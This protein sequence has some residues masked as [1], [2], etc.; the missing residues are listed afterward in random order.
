M[1]FSGGTPALR[2]IM[3]VW[4][5]TAQRTASTKILGNAVGE[6][7]LGWV[8]GKIGERQYDDGEVRRLGRRRRCDGRRSVGPD[9]M[10]GG[11]ASGEQEGDCESRQR[12]H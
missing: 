2:S 12:E 4:T 5:S 8:A 7:V 11:G 3:A 9:E 6:I 10:P 1:R